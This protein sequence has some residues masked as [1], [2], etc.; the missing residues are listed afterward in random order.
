MKTINIHGKKYVPVSERLIY[1]RENYK[2]FSLTTDII[3]LTDTRV[4][5][6]S[7]VK[8]KNGREIANGHAYEILGSTN[9]NK[10]SFL[11]NCETSANGRALANLGIMIED[12]ISSADEVINAI[13]QQN[14]KAV[15]QKLNDIKFNAM[16]QAIKKG[17]IKVVENRMKNYKLA[18]KQE[19]EL[20]RLINEVKI[21]S[22]I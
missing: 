2:D 14:K 5:M 15:K 12:N 6:K 13:E 9:V 22:Q 10:T 1:F 16:K 3:E 7:I 18:K 11:E 4:V 19:T 17:D 21:A 8:D 20:L